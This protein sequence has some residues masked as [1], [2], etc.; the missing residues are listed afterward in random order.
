[1]KALFII[2]ITVALFTAIVETVGFRN[3][4]KTGS[5]SKVY[6]ILAIAGWVIAVIIWLLIYLH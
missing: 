3:Q 2:L 1:M 4:K 5:E 6:N